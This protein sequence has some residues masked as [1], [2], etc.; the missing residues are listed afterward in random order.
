MIFPED[1]AAAAETR[2]TSHPNLFIY[3]CVCAE[4]PKTTEGC[5]CGQGGNPFVEATPHSWHYRQ[6]LILTD[7]TLNRHASVLS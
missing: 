6:G 1:L 3:F 4:I 2:S 7:T 5:G